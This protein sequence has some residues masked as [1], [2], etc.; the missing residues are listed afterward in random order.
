MTAVVHIVCGPAGAGKTRR[1]R[2]HYRGAV[3][4]AIGAALWLGPT[5]RYVE[6]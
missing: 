4:E 6:A 2:E 1:L 3:R 5:A